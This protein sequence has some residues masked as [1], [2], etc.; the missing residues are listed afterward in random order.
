MG[1]PFQNATPGSASRFFASTSKNGCVRAHK[2]NVP[3]IFS[4]NL[5]MVS[6]SA[7]H[8]SKRSLHEHFRF[9]RS[10]SPSTTDDD[11]N[12]DTASSFGQTKTY[13]NYKF[14][15][16]CCRSTG[17]SSTS[18]L[19]PLKGFHC[20]S[21]FHK[22]YESSLQNLS[23]PGQILYSRY[24]YFFL[25]IFKC[26]SFFWNLTVAWNAF[27][28][29]VNTRVSMTTVGSN[30]KHLLSVIEKDRVRW[31]TIIC[32][33]TRATSG[34]FSPSSGSGACQVLSFFVS[35]VKIAYNGVQ[36]F[37]CTY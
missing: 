5:R 25:R 18:N 6:D 24:F 23:G 37:A 15:S 33:L 36:I 8:F 3:S 4:P 11:D 32:L 22:Q 26:Q 9:W 34:N 17:R 12:E 20:D 31:P 1:P 13:E 29:T 19:Q 10:S 27:S 2:P 14:R 7:G 16:R 35:R 30:F 28:C 21:N